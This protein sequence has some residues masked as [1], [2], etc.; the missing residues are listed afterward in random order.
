MALFTEKSLKLMPS[1]GL[2]GLSNSLMVE[3]DKKL[4]EQQTAVS[5][6]SKLTGVAIIKTPMAGRL[7]VNQGGQETAEA[8]Q[9]GM[10]SAAL[11][12][13][14]GASVL[15]STITN[16]ASVPVF[17]PGTTDGDVTLQDVTEMNAEITSFYKETSPSKGSPKM[18]STISLLKQ[19]ASIL[20][21]EIDRITVAQ[22]LIAE[23]LEKRADGTLPEP[24]LNL[25]SLNLEAIPPSIVKMVVE[26]RENL[27][28]FVENTIIAPFAQNELFIEALTAQLSGIDVVSPMFD[29][30]YGPP[31]SAGNKFILSQD[32]LYYNS[33][34]KEVPVIMPNPLS[35]NMWT[36]SYDSNKGGRGV[37]FS[38]EE[39]YAQAGTIF[40][41]ETDLGENSQRVKN[42][43]AYDDVLQ[44]FADDRQAQLLE[45]SGYISQI[46]TEGY[47]ETDA[48]V[49]SY[50]S[51]LG[52]V[53][54][55][56]DT[57]IRKRKRQLEIAA[58][59]G[60]DSFM[61][62]DRDHP[63][64]EGIFFV[65]VAPT[66]KLF[67]YKL[68]YDDQTDEMKT[69][70][71][72]RGEGGQV[73]AWDT[74]ANSV[75][76]IPNAANI[77]G[78]QGQWDEIPRIPLNNFSYLKSSDIPLAVQRKLTLFSEDLDTIIAPYQA[79]YV[80]APDA[81]DNFTEA[82]AVDMIGYGDWVHRE[83]SGSISSITPSYKSLTDDIVSDN[84]IGCYNFL[85]PEAVTQPS[86]T[87]Y[88]LNNAAEGSPRLDGKLVGYSPS[89]VFP[90]GV[91]TA[92]MGGT[93]FDEEAK[94][95]SSWEDVK[96]SYVRLPNIT[97]E[98]EEFRT[99]YNGS[100]ELDNLFYTSSGVSL[101]FWTYVPTLTTGLTSFHRYRLIFSN[102]NSGPVV[103]D[104]VNAAITAKD[105][106]TFG[107]SQPR[108]QTTSRTVGMM[109]GY[110]D[111]GAPTGNGSTKDTSPSGLE[112]IISPTVSQNQYYTE[113]PTAS[114]GHSVCIA[115]TWDGTSL[116]PASGDTSEVGMYITSAVRTE[117]GSGVG[118][119]S[120]SFMH[121]NIS[122]DYSRNETR[123]TLDGK[124]LVTS[125]ISDVLG[126]A[127]QHLQTP[128]AVKMDL[129]DTSQSI[130]Y[131]NP[132]KESFLGNNIYDEYVTPERLAFPVFTPWIIGG[133][134]T[135][136]CPSIAGTAN[137]PMGFLG[138]NTNNTYQGTT[139]GEPTVSESIGTYGDF[140]IG[141]HTPP[142]SNAAGGSSG[143][144]FRIPR[145]GLDGYV[146]SFK[147]YTK[148]LSTTE[149]KANFDSQKGFF[150]NILL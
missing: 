72:L 119:V 127:P 130:V 95:D 32:G 25:N 100:K 110:R 122:F 22:N 102:E 60:R 106:K 65:Y 57:K 88:G 87:L 41:L 76:D 55:T 107:L 61:V 59:Y 51:Q 7:N 124:H 63:L 131:N 20:Q 109:I 19:K 81:P 53:V 73:V 99:P 18:E 114:W 54:A 141:Q 96:G 62:T 21:T 121:F 105:I 84:L 45:V 33:R 98:Y 40:A 23:I 125:S 135:D 14:N 83:S 4:S 1:N 64:G 42:F 6:V 112:F 46:K 91:G 94:L 38:E 36:L 137:R 8:A 56:Y 30:E 13:A 132:T 111:R 66:G 77:I 74:S 138:S 69:I 139:M 82:L 24:L 103:N 136:N 145:S 133:G 12:W 31:I 92:Y 15:N 126:M 10:S 49:Q 3:K 35:S 97:K 117:A 108:A 5:K 58:I 142:L 75:V 26:S 80:V 143:S 148:P 149:A 44:Q 39:G 16:P 146:G 115:E 67:E 9:Q 17:V 129:R 52:A 71:F 29:L 147:I 48:V 34:T 113:N 93:L 89:F 85:D 86:G 120:G 144:R 128:T 78:V 50:Y 101:D 123:V 27:A 47:S 150:K 43:Y 68:R 116:A 140:L 79:R 70:S 134:Y 90:S 37:E 104:Y 11:A 28:E 118:D 2:T